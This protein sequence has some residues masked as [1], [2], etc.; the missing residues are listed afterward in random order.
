MRQST[1]VQNRNEQS[2][3]YDQQDKRGPFDGLR[4]RHLNNHRSKRNW[5]KIE[6]QRDDAHDN[7]LERASW[8]SAQQEEGRNHVDWQDQIAAAFSALSEHAGW[9]VLNRSM[10]IAHLVVG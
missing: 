10:P 8:D 1:S 3:Q 4:K 6:S 2:P 5:T 9:N 7:E